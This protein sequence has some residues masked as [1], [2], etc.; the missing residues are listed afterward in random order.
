MCKWLYTVGKQRDSF[1]VHIAH[2][3]TPMCVQHVYN[4]PI[5]VH[6]VY[7]TQFQTFA[8]C[9]SVFAMCFRLFIVM[10]MRVL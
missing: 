1:G 9:F 3:S 8:E 2:T 5:V 6:Y 7:K 10:E 4:S